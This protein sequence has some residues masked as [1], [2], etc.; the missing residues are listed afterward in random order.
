MVLFYNRSVQVRKYYLGGTTLQAVGFMLMEFREKGK[1]G[2][3]V[4]V[5]STLSGHGS[6]L[7][8]LHVVY[9]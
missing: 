6:V 3:S 4:W 7:V 5:W 9:S 8:F 1:L 2:S